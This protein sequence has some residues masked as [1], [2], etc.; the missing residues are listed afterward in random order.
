M[1]NFF[2]KTHKKLSDDHKPLNYA[3]YANGE[4]ILLVIEILIV[5]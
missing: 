2:R 4:I 3:R 5:L 1:N